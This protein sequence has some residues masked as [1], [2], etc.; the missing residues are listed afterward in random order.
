VKDPV[1]AARIEK[2]AEQADCQAGELSW[3]SHEFRDQ[4]R[5]LNANYNAK[6]KEF[7]NL[8]AD[9]KLQRQRLRDGI[10]DLLFRIR[11]LATEQEWKELSGFERRAL[12]QRLLD[13]T[14]G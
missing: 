4:L 2:L 8:I 10:I 12:S 13:E 14:V 11:K 7:K 6:P 1:R 3:F 9:F 5:A